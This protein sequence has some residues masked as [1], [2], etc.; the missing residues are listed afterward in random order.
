MQY[1]AD[2]DRPF[3]KRDAGCQKTKLADNAREHA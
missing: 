2:A 3:C 1:Y